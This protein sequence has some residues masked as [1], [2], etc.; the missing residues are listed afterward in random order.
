MSRSAVEN[1]SNHRAR[2]LS[3]SAD[4]VLLTGATGFLGSELLARYLEQTDRPIYALVRGSSEREA[5]ARLGATL[6]CLFGADHPYAR[7]LHAV[8]GDITSPGLGLGRRRDAL[9][10]RVN[11][12]VHAAASVSFVA[13]LDELRSVNV[14]GTKRMLELAGRCQERGGLERFT[15]VSTAYVAGE[16]NG[17]F[18][19]DELDVGQRFRNPYERTKFEAEH[20]VKG[21]RARLPTTV[22]RPSIIV[23]E[24]QSGWTA[25][26]NVLY[27]PLRVFS[28]GSYVALPA[29]GCSPVDVVSVDY[30]ADAIFALSQAPEAEGATFH[31][32]A[33]R[34]ASSV[35]ELVALASSFFE[36]PPPRLIE[37]R[38][39]RRLVH[40]LLI[41]ASRDQRSR[42]ALE[43]SEVFFPYFAARVRYDDRRARALLHPTGI[44]PSP[45]HDYFDRLVEFALLA[46]WGRKPIPRSGGVVSLSDVRRR[47]RPQ[48][49][50]ERLVLAG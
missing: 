2:S 11:E 5:S 46:A 25:S 50:H 37:P 32:T 1:S 3:A 7:R 17:C 29:R 36:R 21:A 15:Y 13:E 4:G 24:R 49:R 12:I 19:E 39:Y 44:E 31:I 48:R 26:F 14:Q 45:L 43:R 40:P 18:S 22:V 35:D 41:R 16:H 9:A 27:W 28:R 47:S 34:H 23:G 8:P 10:E 6:L 42:R 20:L 38:L 30:V 33:G